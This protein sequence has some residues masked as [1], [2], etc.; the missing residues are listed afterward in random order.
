MFGRA[1]LLRTRSFPA[2]VTVKL[3]LLRPVTLSPRATN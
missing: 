3:E 2:S 1:E